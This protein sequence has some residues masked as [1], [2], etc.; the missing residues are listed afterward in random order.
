MLITLATGAAATEAPITGTVQSACS[1][2]TSTEGVYG[3]PSVDELSTDPADGGVHPVIRVDTS[4]GD[5]YIAKVTTPSSFS[6]SPS[7]TDTLTWTGDVTVKQVSDTAMANYDTDKV[8]YNNTHE[9]DLTTAGS[10]WLEI[11][12][13]VTYA[14]GKALPGGTYVAKVVAE[15]IA[16]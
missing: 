9:Y 6:S 2:Y 1:I 8:T 4:L 7:I 10:V 15:C 12:S 14:Q 5:A 3:T 16:Q 13:G 11:E